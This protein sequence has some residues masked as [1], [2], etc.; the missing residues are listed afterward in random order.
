MSVVEGGEGL[1]GCA[2]IAT[3]LERIIKARNRQLRKKGK[4]LDT[5]Q[6]LNVNRGKQNVKENQAW[7]TRRI[8]LLQGQ[9]GF[10]EEY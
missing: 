10:W 9:R 8:V 7:R 5:L 4:Y 3:V 1:G 2:D 6:C